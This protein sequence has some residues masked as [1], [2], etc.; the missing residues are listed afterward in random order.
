MPAKAGIQNYLKTLDFRLR[1]ND[2]KRRF[3]TFYGTINVRRSMFD[4]RVC[5]TFIFQSDLTLIGLSRL[6]LLR[7]GAAQVVALLSGQHGLAHAHGS[8]CDL[9]QLIVADK[10]D[11]L[12]Q[13]QGFDGR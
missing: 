2:A 3:K 5:S 7:P 1:G 9:H 13:G 11:G 4:V 6:I 12:L 8:G 10:A